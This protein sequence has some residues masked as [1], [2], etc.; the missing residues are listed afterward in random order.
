MTFPMP[1]V[2]GELIKCLLDQYDRH[3][4]RIPKSVY[5]SMKA[6]EEYY[7]I[8]KGMMWVKRNFGTRQVGRHVAIAGKINEYGGF[9]DCESWMLVS[10]NFVSKSGIYSGKDGG[11]YQV[12]VG[13]DRVTAIDLKT[14]DPYSVICETGELCEFEDTGSGKYLILESVDAKDS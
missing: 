1:D 6:V 12:I 8:P 5:D 10:K 14:G 9:S 11:T 7:K 2:V 4:N 3:G 13:T